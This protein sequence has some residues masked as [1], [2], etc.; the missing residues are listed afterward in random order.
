MV[1]CK[2][3][4]Y[5]LSP[6]GQVGS[7][8]YC[9]VS[10]FCD[11]SNQ[12]PNALLAISGFRGYVI[13][14]IRKKEE[15]FCVIMITVTLPPRKAILAPGAQLDQSPCRHE[16]TDHSPLMFFNHNRNIHIYS[17]TEDKTKTNLIPVFCSMH[18]QCIVLIHLDQFSPLPPLRKQIVSRS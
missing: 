5:Y 11:I 4:N 13:G 2:Y 18:C 1:E 17:L 14:K 12:R 10:K 8:T 16:H 3:S 7:L 6:L 15:A 9:I